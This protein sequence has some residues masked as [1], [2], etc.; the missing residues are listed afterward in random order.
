M[1]FLEQIRSILHVP[2]DPTEV[3]PSCGWDA[4]EGRMGTALPQDYKLFI[5]EFGSGR[6]DRFLWIFNPFSANPYLNLEHA[7]KTQTAALSELRTYG[8]EIPFA[9]FPESE[10]ILPFAI[11]DNGD[12]LYWI[13]AG[14]PCHWTVI[15]NEARGPEWQHFKMPF[16]EFLAGLLIKRISCEVFPDD[17]PSESPKF[18]AVP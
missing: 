9:C 15:V 14:S 13:T 18:Q 6:I 17:F 5:H 8:E 3:P 4:L 2:S 12:V 16:S 1:K 10:G 7:L 11:T